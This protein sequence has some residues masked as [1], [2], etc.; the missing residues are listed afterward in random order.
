[1]GKDSEHIFSTFTFS[2]EEENAYYDSVLKKFND[3]F[4]PKRNT[5]HE[6]AQFHRR[7]QQSGESVEAFV[8]NLY[9]LAEHCEF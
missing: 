3:Y 5:I 9:E 8:R 7:A 2:Q 1:M 6:R 4:V